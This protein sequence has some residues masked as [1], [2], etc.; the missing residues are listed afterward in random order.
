MK[1]LTN[2]EKELIEVIRNFQAS[3]GRMEFESD[4]Y[5]YIHS[6]LDNLLYPDGQ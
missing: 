1:R 2:K 4:F 6:V 3:K 5:F